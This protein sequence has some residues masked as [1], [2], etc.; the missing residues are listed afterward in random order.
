MSRSKDIGTRYET[1]VAREFNRRAGETVAERVVLHGN[2]DNGDL[3][4]TL[5]GHVLTVECKWNKRYPSH[6]KEMDFRKQTLDETE[7]AGTDA[8]VLVMN[9]YQNGIERHEC[10]T[11]LWVLDMLCGREYDP[12]QDLWV[13]VRMGELCDL[14]F[15]K[16]EE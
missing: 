9:R 10:W 6:G 16:E 14:L 4:L 7:H 8:G 5:P 12:E 11:Q 15:G 3:R 1:Q 2:R 13:M